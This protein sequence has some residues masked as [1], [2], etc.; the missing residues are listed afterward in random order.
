MVLPVKAL[1]RG[2]PVIG[3]KLSAAFWPK[4]QFSYAWP[5][6]IR[7]ST[8]K[9]NRSDNDFGRKSDFYPSKIAN[10]KANY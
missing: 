1:G 9:Q 2:C 4:N 8:I 5:L 6:E 10:F 3:L 7:L